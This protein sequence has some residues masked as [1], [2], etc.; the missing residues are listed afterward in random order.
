MVTAQDD[1]IAYLSFYCL[2][3]QFCFCKNVLYM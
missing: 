2:Q 1:L 3:S